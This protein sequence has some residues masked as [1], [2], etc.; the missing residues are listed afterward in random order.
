MVRANIQ[1]TGGVYIGLI[2]EVDAG[3]RIVWNRNMDNYQERNTMEHNRIFKTF[4][5]ACQGAYGVLPDAKITETIYF[6][7]KNGE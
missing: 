3:F 2:D 1:N 7:R 6:R 4:D 5:E